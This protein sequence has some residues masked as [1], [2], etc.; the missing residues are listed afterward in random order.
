MTLLV[1]AAAPEAGRFTYELP[2]Q[3]LILLLCA[4]VAGQIQTEST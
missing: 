2:S 3:R 1:S 4:E